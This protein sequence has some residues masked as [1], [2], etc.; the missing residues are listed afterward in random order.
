GLRRSIALDR[1][2]ADIG[3]HAAGTGAGRRE[4][5]ILRRIKMLI[6]LVGRDDLVLPGFAVRVVETPVVRSP[7]AVQARRY[8]KQAVDAG[9]ALLLRRSAIQKLAHDKGVG[10]IGAAII[11]LG[12]RAGHEKGRVGPIIA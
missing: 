7:F 6:V 1:R 11:A 9:A 10:G 4:D 12:A 2:I 8:R 3:G 5:R